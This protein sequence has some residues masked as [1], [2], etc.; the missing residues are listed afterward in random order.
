MRYSLRTLLTVFALELWFLFALA[1]MFI[2]AVGV[3]W[4]ANWLYYGEFGTFS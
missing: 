2:A 4:V 3:I 1:F